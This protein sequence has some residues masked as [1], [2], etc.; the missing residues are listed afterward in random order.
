[1]SF[2]PSRA[3]LSARARSA[4]ASVV[5]TIA[6]SSASAPRAPSLP[7]RRAAS[8]RRPRI[9]RATGLE[10]ARPRPGVIATSSD[11]KTTAGS[12][13]SARKRLFTNSGVIAAMAWASLRQNDDSSAGSSGLQAATKPPQ[14]GR[15]AAC[16]QRARAASESGL[17]GSLQNANAR[18][19]IAAS[20]SA[21]AC[22]ADPS[23]ERRLQGLRS[24]TS[25]RDD[26]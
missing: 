14:S 4:S 17:L 13:A 21:C 20:T 3:R 24:P 9:E 2:L 12:R 1:M 18:S 8:R 16:G 7:S 22:A 26:R 15:L 6:A 23:G 10:E 19:R 25:G 5:S 11:R